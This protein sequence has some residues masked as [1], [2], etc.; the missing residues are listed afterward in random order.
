[1]TLLDP[2]AARIDD[3]APS[4]DIYPEEV[5]RLLGIT[6]GDFESI[7]AEALLVAVALPM[8]T[9]AWLSL[10]PTAS[11]RPARPNTAAQFV[12]LK[13]GTPLSTIVGTSGNCRREGRS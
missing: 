12:T 8:P 7:L 2:N 9:R 6:N 13:L 1:M 10:L 4:L 5:L 11:G 3:L